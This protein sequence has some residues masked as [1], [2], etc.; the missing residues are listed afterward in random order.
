MTVNLTRPMW[1]DVTPLRNNR[2]FR[3]LLSFG[4]AV[5]CLALMNAMPD[6][7][8]APHS[9]LADAAIGIRYAL[10]KPELIGTYVID[11]AAMLFAFE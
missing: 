1:I 9:P 10:S 11:I 5:V 3:L 6:P 8:V 4:G 7:V 2:D